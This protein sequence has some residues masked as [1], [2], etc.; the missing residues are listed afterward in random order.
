LVEVNLI[1]LFRKSDFVPLQ[2]FVTK[3]SFGLVVP[4]K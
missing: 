1:H 2:D 3:R 4:L